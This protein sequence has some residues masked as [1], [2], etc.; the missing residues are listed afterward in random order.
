MVV[1]VAVDMFGNHDVD[2]VPCSACAGNGLPYDPPE[3]V[4]DLPPRP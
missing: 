2:L 1:S 4:A 3:T